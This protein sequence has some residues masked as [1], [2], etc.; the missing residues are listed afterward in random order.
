[1]DVKAVFV[2]KDVKSI[3]ELFI[4]KEFVFKEPLIF[5][6]KLGEISVSIPTEPEI[7]PPD[8]FR[9]LLLAFII[10]KYL[11]IKFEPPSF[12]LP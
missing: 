10:V 12:K 11:S 5:N 1:M 2:E 8:N 7:I 9:K 3:N 4:Y 6:L